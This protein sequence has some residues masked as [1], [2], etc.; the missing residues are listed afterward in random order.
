MPITIELTPEVLAR[1][2]EKAAREG[3]DAAAV[4]ADI[5]ADA[6]DWEAADREAIEGIRR[7]LADFES[8][9]SPLM[10]VYYADT[11]ALAG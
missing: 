6:L 2:R 10:A 11:S 1:L 5:L 9:G 3:R 4:A 8:R 7:G